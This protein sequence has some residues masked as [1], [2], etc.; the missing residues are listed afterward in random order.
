M[1]V[2]IAASAIVARLM[3]GS[4]AAVIAVLTI[5]LLQCAV[6]GAMWTNMYPPAAA[7]FALATAAGSLAYRRPSIAVALA[8]G[9][10]AGVAWRINH[11]GLV[12]VPMG[13]GLRAGRWAVRIA[14]CGS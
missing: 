6:E 13:L 12:A 5:P 11:L 9:V 2:V 3:A 8:T 1:L 4:G 14:S 7:A 10:L